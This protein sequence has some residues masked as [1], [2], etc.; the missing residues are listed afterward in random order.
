VREAGRET[1]ETLVYRVLAAA[2]GREALEVYRSAVG[3]DLVVTDIVMPEMGGKELVQELK[4]TNPY[5]KAVAITGHAAEGI[6][7]LRKEGILDIIQKPLDV[8]TLAQVIR[9]VLDADK[10]PVEKDH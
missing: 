4:K 2:N 6:Q 1:L 9:R 10:T 7:G 3:V 8:N 5:L